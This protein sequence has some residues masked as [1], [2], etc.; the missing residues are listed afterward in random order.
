MGD[1]LDEDEAFVAALED[2]TSAMAADN[3]DRCA[4]IFGVSVKRFLSDDVRNAPA[5]L[6]FRALDANAIRELRAGGAHQALGEFL[7]AAEDLEDL[8]RRRAAKGVGGWRPLHGLTDLLA[9]V[10]VDDRELF[11][12]AESCARDVRDRLELGDG[13]VPSMIDLFEKRLHVPIF[14]ATPDELD[15][16]IDGASTREPVAAVLVNLV[17]GA[18]RWWRT[19]MTLAHELCHLLFDSLPDSTQRRMVMFSPHRERDLHEPRF[20]PYELP[21]LLERMEKRANAFAAHFMA[22]GRAV[23][24][25]VS[26]NDATSESAITLLCQHFSIGRITAINQLS[27]V[28]HL[29]RQE[30]ARMLDRRST[31]SLPYDHP[32]AHVPRSG[33]P[34]C[35]VLEQWVSDALAQ[36]WIGAVRARDY[37]GRRLGDSLRDPA[38]PPALRAAFRSEAESVRL[39]VQAYLGGSDQ[40]AMW[41]VDEPVRDG[42]YWRVIVFDVGGAGV[43][44]DRGTVVMSQAH[45]IVGPETSLNLQDAE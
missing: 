3:L 11:R 37:L 35:H 41:Q 21:P 30:R 32:D 43:R 1:L 22:P 27:N 24:A 39:R 8:A 29:S 40:T 34:R 2:G 26:R 25:L 12:E 14:W 17:G 23:R 9:S 10:P 6:L 4:R 33:R 5:L 31:E 15:A 20:R 7:R 19:R 18:E 44:R 28:F 36:G 42:A 45:K 38:L 13:A 16:N